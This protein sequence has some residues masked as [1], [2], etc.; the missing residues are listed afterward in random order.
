MITE[1][2]VIPF[3][4]RAIIGELYSGIFLCKLMKCFPVMQIMRYVKRKQQTVACEKQL[5]I[6]KSIICL[7]FV[8]LKTDS[9]ASFA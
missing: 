3:T 4:V 8:Q 6:L 2:V 9:L 1:T 5:T 7:A